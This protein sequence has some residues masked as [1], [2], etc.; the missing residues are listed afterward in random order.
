LKDRYG[1][2]RDQFKPVIDE[3]YSLHGWDV[4][5]GQPTKQRLDELGLEGVHEQMT[6][7]AGKA[8]G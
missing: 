8:I 2:D 7:S 4:Q 3:F 5:T 6:A 1:L